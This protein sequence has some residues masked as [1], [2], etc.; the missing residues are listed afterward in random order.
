MQPALNNRSY[1]D[2]QRCE[3]DTDHAHEFDQDVQG[4]TGSVFAGVTDGVADN[5]CRM[6]F[7]SLSAVRTLF[8]VLLGVVPRPRAVR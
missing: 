3:H 2:Y 5:A 4:R 1:F 8:D 7:S 6:S